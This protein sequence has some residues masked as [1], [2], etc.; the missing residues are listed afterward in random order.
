M[1]EINPMEPDLYEWCSP[2]RLE[3]IDSEL[4]SA[5]R[6]L[7]WAEKL[8]HIVLGWV[9]REILKDVLG[10][11]DIWSK[12]EFNEKLSK[13][14]SQSHSEKGV[15]TIPP[16]AEED[17]NLWYL[18]EEGLLAW[19]RFHWEYK[20]ESLYLS[21]KQDLDVISCSLLRIK[22]QHMAF[23]IYQRIKSKESTFEQMSWQYG[24]G[25]EK[26]IG[27]KFYH[28]RLRDLPAFFRPLLAK[29]QVGEI[30][31]PHRNGK[32]FII[33]SLDEYAPSKFDK[34]AEDLLLRLELNIWLKAVSQH[35]VDHLK[36][37][38]T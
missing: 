15:E 19:A 5:V 12:S 25:S 21:Q 14:H 3:L 20:L 30:L 6:S 23:E 22:N 27:G 11:K 8:D 1:N 37:I 2:C 28:K 29:L 32:W 34:N 9:R 31:K 38:H 7:L 24:E 4:G 33:V 35:L 10:D 16:C 13:A 26:N 36:C 18:A 17:K